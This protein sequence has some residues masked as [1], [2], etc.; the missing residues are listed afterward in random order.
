MVRSPRRGTAREQSTVDRPDHLGDE[1]ISNARYPCRGLDPFRL[2]EFEGRGERDGQGDVLRARPA[3]RFLTP[4]VDD[5]FDRDPGADRGHP[6]A[7]RRTDLVPGERE[8]ID[9][10]VGQRQPPGSLDGIGVRER[11]E[12][13]GERGEFGDC[14]DRAD[15][16]VRIPEADDG[17]VLPQH[18][19]QSFG[20]DRAVGL[21]VDE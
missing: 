4:A 11:T 1:G 5:R 10:E 7:L 3:P 21:D 19:P 9:A 16:V 2:G 18:C 12:L 17:G 20:S 13:A 14:G 15:L 6:D 8:G